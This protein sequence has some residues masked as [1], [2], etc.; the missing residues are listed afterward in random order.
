[1]SLS[2]NNSS[3]H[4]V[5]SWT[6][7]WLFLSA[8]DLVARGR[9]LGLHVGL[10][11]NGS[12]VFDGVGKVVKNVRSREFMLKRLIGRYFELIGTEDLHPIDMI[13]RYLLQEASRFDVD[14]SGYASLCDLPNLEKL[15]QI[16]LSL[17]K[18]LKGIHWNV[19]RFDGGF[20]AEHS[21]TIKCSGILKSTDL[22]IFRAWQKHPGGQGIALMTCAI[23]REDLEAGDAISA[24]P[25]NKHQFHQECLE[26]YLVDSGNYLCPLCRTPVSN[27][28]LAKL[29]PASK[30]FSYIE[31]EHLINILD[32]C[33][34]KCMD[35]LIGVFE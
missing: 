1:M 27:E 20:L 7:F 23:C 10:S 34:A 5:S 11:T 9:R 31:D 28:I 3:T 25:N 4:S 12:A 21:L 32:A 8:I 17:Q 26:G 6:R 15:V 29:L 24:H 19:E 35:C 2:R 22:K 33:L 18:P 16:Q 14:I 13:N 30:L